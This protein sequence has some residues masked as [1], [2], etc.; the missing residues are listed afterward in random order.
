MKPES[1]PRKISN[2]TEP[3]ILSPKNDFV[4]RLLFGE[5]GNE[6]LLASLLASILDKEIKDIR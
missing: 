3:Y 4:F 2:G 6:D 1:K 5:E